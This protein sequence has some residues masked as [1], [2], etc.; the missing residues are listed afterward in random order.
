MTGD[1]IVELKLKTVHLP[2]STT[3]DRHDRQ[4]L[5]GVK[6]RSV[7]HVEER[8]QKRM[9]EGHNVGEPQHAPMQVNSR[10]E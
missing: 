4:C 6:R 9:K 5:R 7:V 1:P 8:S 10:E 2:T 3:G